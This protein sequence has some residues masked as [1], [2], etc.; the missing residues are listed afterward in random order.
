MKTN[1]TSTTTKKT[2]ENAMPKTDIAETV[3]VQEIKKAAI[4]WG[5]HNALLGPVLDMTN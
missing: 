1:K 2:K 3:S 4:E 5:C